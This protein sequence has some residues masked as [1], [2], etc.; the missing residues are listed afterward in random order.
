MVTKITWQ[1]AGRVAEPGRYMF[2]LGGSPWLPRISSSGRNSPTRLSRLFRCRPMLTAPRSFASAR[3]TC[4]ATSR[5]AVSAESNAARFS[6]P[7][8]LG[9]HIGFRRRRVDGTRRPCPR[10]GNRRFSL[11]IACDR[12]RPR[13][14]DP[15]RLDR[16][17]DKAAVKASPQHHRTMPPQPFDT[18]D[19]GGTA[20]RRR[21][22]GHD[23][24]CTVAIV[25]QRF[26]ALR[27]RHEFRAGALA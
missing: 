19:G 12:W 11:V 25:R 24:G 8:I 17:D 4:R 5:L 15:C 16:I 7:L 20:C 22:R 2:K 10:R 18:D 26:G 3:S 13:T 21:P 6:N 1:K 23:Q 14:V 27:Q 9:L